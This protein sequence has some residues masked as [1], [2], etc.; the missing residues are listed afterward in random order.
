MFNLSVRLY[1]ERFE[2]Y[3]LLYDILLPFPDDNTIKDGG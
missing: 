1:L 2:L 3:L